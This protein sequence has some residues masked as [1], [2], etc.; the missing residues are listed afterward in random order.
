[1][2]PMKTLFDTVNE[3]FFNFFYC[4]NLEERQVNFVFV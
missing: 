1:M 3:C 2:L 4:S